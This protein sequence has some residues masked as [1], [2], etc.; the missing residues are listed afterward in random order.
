MHG[1]T[2]ENPRAAQSAGEEP[3]LCVRLRRRGWRILRLDA[4][5]TRHDAASA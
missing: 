4:E 3:E 1:E 2:P 5:M